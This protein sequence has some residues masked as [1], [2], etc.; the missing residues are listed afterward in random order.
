MR[1]QISPSI[2]S[3]DFANLEADL[4]S[5]S[6]ADMIHIDV[7][8][9]HFVPNLT[10]GLPVVKRIREVSKTVLDVHLMIENP[11]HW[12]SK[13][14]ELGADSVT[15]HLEA[16]R[17]PYQ[18]IRSIRQSGSRVGLAIKPDTPL[19]TAAPY[20]PLID[21]LLV[22]TVE[23]GFGGQKL[24]ERVL[25]KVTSSRELVESQGLNVDIQVDGG[26]TLENIASVAALGANVFVAGTA[27][28]VADDRNAR[29]EKLRQLAT[30]LK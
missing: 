21:M 27:V 18:V 25:P 26:I 24:I 19:E 16:A 9:G 29:I 2:L 1:V 8:D 12:A 15:F 28:F 20:L 22:M 3:A 4:T 10:I 13:Y 17:D 30:T 14:A 7:M 5:I 11:E 23:P 6:T